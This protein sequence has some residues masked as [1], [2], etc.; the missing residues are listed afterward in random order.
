MAEFSEAL[1]EAYAS[2]PV[3]DVVME[4]LEFLH[5]SFV[6]ENGNPDS[7]RLVNDGADLYATLEAS[8]PHLPGQTVRF[9]AF[10]FTA[11]PPGFESG[12]TP[13]LVI[14]VDNVGRELTAQL[15]AA[16]ASQVP[17][18]V[19]YRIY[20]ITDLSGPQMDPPIMMNMIKASADVM[21][22]QV[23]ATLDDVTN[24]PFPRRLYTP[25]DFPGLVR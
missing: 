6:D 10:A 9:M 20:L 21:K 3:G 14:T 23:T 12:Q 24:I 5:P 17:V 1:K 7:L 8:A 19:I 15:E 11:K 13:N 16:T 22:V 4:T 25:D 18:Q 2:N